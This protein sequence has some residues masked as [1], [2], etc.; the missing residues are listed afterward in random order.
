MYAVGCPASLMAK[1][2]GPV[3]DWSDRRTS[4]PASWFDLSCQV[5]AIRVEST[6]VATTFAGA[7]RPPA[8]A[9]A[10]AR[11]SAGSRSNTGATSARR[12]ERMR[13]SQR[14]R[15]AGKSG[16]PKSRPPRFSVRAIF[17]LPKMELIHKRCGAESRE[18]RIDSRCLSRLAADW[19][20]RYPPLLYAFG[21]EALR[22]HLSMALPS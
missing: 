16:D 1:F 22:H 20:P 17:P 8:L 15:L 14:M 13:S 2:Q 10:G 21:P 18:S 5:I 12:N 7:V 3:A 9:K 4:N 6:A 11:R 19:Q